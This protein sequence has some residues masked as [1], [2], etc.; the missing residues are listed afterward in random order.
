MFNEFFVHC[1]KLVIKNCSWGIFLLTTAHY[2]ISVL[3]YRELPK[4][5]DINDNWQLSF[6]SLKKKSFVS[7]VPTEEGCEIRTKKI[8]KIC[9]VSCQHFCFSI[10]QL[11]IMLH[12]QTLR[13]LLHG[14]QRFSLALI[15]FHYFDLFQP[16]CSSTI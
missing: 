7:F 14:W 2:K 11:S 16:F 4:N 9:Q 13:Q 10:Y 8:I 3:K 1:K 6:F 15:S 12:L 5:Y